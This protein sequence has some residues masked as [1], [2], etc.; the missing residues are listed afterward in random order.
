MRQRSVNS[1]LVMAA[2]ACGLMLVAAGGVMAAQD[3]KVPVAGPM[4]PEASEGLGL[5]MYF[6]ALESRVASHP[7]LKGKFNYKLLD[8]GTLFGTQDECVS[9]VASGAAQLTYAGT[10]FLEAFAPEWKLVQS[11]GFFENWTHFRKTMDTPAWK[12]LHEKMA[13]EKG[14]TIVKWMA[15]IGSWFL[16][17]NKGP[18]KT[19]ADVKGQKIRIAGGEGFAKALAAMGAA[20]I[21]LPYTEVVTALQTNMINGL[22][23][24]ML[25]AIY[26]YNL[27]RYTKHVVPV[28]WAIQPIC[29]VV[30]TKWWESLD[31][32]ARTAMQ[33]VFDRIDVA[34]FYDGLEGMLVQKW[35]AGPETKVNQL[36]QAEAERWKATMTEAAKSVAAGIDPKFI[37]AIKAS[38]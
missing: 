18:I 32:K 17:T 9:G 8:K 14:L 27:P 10:H 35:G 30:N 6:S 5:N 21:S 28:T 11:P 7:D 37:E 31:P 2:L 12:G 19:A 34:N 20:S 36:D 29:L 3:I 25:G 22:L 4:Y 1:F 26:F 23:T 24:D 15:N 33:D 16:Y 38:K 13:K